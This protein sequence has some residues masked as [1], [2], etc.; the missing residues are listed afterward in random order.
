MWLEDSPDEK[1]VLMLPNKI[2]IQFIIVS[3]VCCIL[4]YCV[5]YM[6][7]SCSLPA[8]AVTLVYTAEFICSLSCLNVPNNQ[9]S[10]YIKHF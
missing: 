4:P 3:E 10:D 8:S 2:Q 6:H 5:S 1:S 9:E 7:L